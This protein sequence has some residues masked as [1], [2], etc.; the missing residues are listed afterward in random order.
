MATSA[1]LQELHVRLVSLARDLARAQDELKIAQRCLLTLERA[2]VDAS[3]GRE[4][5][6]VD[7]PFGGSP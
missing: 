3:D 1:T 4:V 5:L 6:P 7:P 2:E